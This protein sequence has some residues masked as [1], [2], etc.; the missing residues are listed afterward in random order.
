[1]RHS[2]P[3]TCPRSGHH[4]SWCER[5]LV[6]V[7]VRQEVLRK[8]IPM[9]VGQTMAYKR[10]EN[11]FTSAEHAGGM[12]AHHDLVRAVL[13]ADS[14]D[15]VHFFLAGKPKDDTPLERLRHSF[16]GREIAVHPLP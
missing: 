3:L 13:A 14:I 6:F 8:G 11:E 15:G 2:D 7:E 12:V 5:S 16:A 10:H 9:I 4:P 1:M